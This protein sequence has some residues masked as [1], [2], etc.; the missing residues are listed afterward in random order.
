MKRIA[1]L[2][3]LEWLKPALPVFS[4]LTSDGGVARAVGGCVRDSILGRT[5][6]DIDIATNITPQKCAIL[7]EKAGIEVVPLGIDHGS[8]MAIVNN[9]SFDITTLRIDVETHG[10][11][12]TIEYTDDWEEDAKRRDFTMNAIYMDV[13]GSIYDP[14]GGIEDIKDGKVRFI[15]SP[16]TRIK[17][18]YLRILRLFRF[19]AN[20]G[21][22][23][24]DD[25]AL[26][27]CVRAKS[28]LASLSGE[29]ILGE[30]K[31]LLLAINCVDTVEIMHNLGIFEA[32]FPESDMN[33][34]ALKDLVM[35]E[36]I[37][38]IPP[39]FIRRLSAMII[40]GHDKIA[41]RLRMAN[42]DKRH[43]LILSK[44]TQTDNIQDIYR[45]L[46]N[47]GSQIS[48]DLL[49]LKQKDITIL[50]QMMSQVRNWHPNKFP[51]NGGDLIAIGFK[52][53]PEIG[54]IMHDYSEWW[55]SNACIPD[56]N[57]SLTWIKNHRNKL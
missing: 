48:Q 24:L 23:K 16:E 45:I 54:Q 57:E 14:C 36:S 29:R 30:L 44:P 43:L 42:K 22:T 33:I 50:V 18:D 35:N 10:R 2:P 17:E 19:Q 55:F 15:G 32:I 8:I 52:E 9:K 37:L 3:D 31:K 11:H 46:Y 28:K 40:T 34:Q 1:I 26:H 5:I 20:Y 38:E 21:N 39:S 51:I 56:R 49:L 7:L 41:E 27:A 47:Y 12:A 6:T 13:D 53:G 25:D 4:A